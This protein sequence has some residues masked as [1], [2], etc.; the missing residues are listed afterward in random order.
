MQSALDAVTGVAGEVGPGPS[1]PGGT[2]RLAES[3][4]R[5]HS[6][7]HLTRHHSPSSSLPSSTSEPSSPSSSDERAPHASSSAYTSASATS[8]Q[9]RPAPPAFC[10]VPPEPLTTRARVRA[11]T[12]LPRAARLAAAHRTAA[13]TLQAA[14]L[15][16]LRKLLRPSASSSTSRPHARACSLEALARA[17]FWPGAE[18]L[19]LQPASH[20]ARRASLAKGQ[21]QGE[22]QGQG[23]GLGQSQPRK[24]G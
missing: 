19:L 1:R 6:P 7:N 15:R 23:R 24:G 22:G 9:P 3:A 13:G 18:G 11:R 21:G 10:A 14:R 2:R 20:G 17:S 4:P 16:W 8:G 5:S 12:R